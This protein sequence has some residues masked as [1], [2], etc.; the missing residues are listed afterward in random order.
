[1]GLIDQMLLQ[2]DDSR[3]HRALSNERS[4]TGDLAGG[5]NGYLGDMLTTKAR[6]C[7]WWAS[8]MMPRSAM[9]K[10]KRRR[11][12]D[13]EISAPRRRARRSLR[14]Q[15]SR[16]SPTFTATS[17]AS[18]AR[19]WPIWP[20]WPLCSAMTHGCKLLPGRFDAVTP[21]QIQQ[22][23]QRYMKPEQR[24]TFTIIPGKPAAKGAQ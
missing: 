22:V 1:M 6:R 5:I 14:G 23:A 7:G 15:R 13:L 17:Q 9:P 2:G 12:G 18:A 19:A 21:E 8:R 11:Q 10:S 16:R 20:G 24:S 3:L 4:I